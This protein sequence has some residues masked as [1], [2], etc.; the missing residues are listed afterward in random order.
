MEEEMIAN[1]CKG[2]ALAI[3]FVKRALAYFHAA[4]DVL[5]KQVEKEFIIK[6]MVMGQDLYCHP[7]FMRHAAALNTAIR[8]CISTY[9]D[10]VAWERAIDPEKVAWAD[11]A[12]HAGMDLVLVVADIC[13]GW[14]HRRKVSLELRG[15]NLS[16]AAMEKEIEKG[17]IEKGE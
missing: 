9:A 5:D 12:R 1:A 10:S 14:E 11:F 17:E 2:D 16:Y 15:Y 3:D 8:T 4:D 7:F 13:G 6:V